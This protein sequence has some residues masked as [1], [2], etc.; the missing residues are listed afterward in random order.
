MYL[1]Q[2]AVRAESLEV[3]RMCKQCYAETSFVHY[4]LLETYDLRNH[5]HLVHL[6]CLLPAQKKDSEHEAVQEKGA[7]S[8][9]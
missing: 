5:G 6:T 2:H 4:T 8:G 1:R 9:T 3:P 7:Y